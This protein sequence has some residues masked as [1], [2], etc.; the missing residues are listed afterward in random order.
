MPEQ[1][2]AA[3][4]SV[5]HPDHYTSSPAK[6]G[7]CGFPI[8]CIQVVEHAGFNIGNAMKY[9]WRHEHK[10][11]P[12]VDLKKSLWYIAREIERRTRKQEPT[13]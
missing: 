7:N 2:Q 12:I 11:S 10:S 1:T 6:C 5:N 9:L 3:G 8:E 13:P 4:D